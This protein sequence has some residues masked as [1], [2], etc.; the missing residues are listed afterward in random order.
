MRSISCVRL[1]I[2]GT[3]LCAGV[4]C[5]PLEPLSS[6]VDVHEWGTFTSMADWQGNALEGLHHTEEPLPKFVYRRG[7]SPYVTKG[8]ESMPTG[9][10]QKLETPVIYF[11]SA[12]P[13]LMHA[14]VQ[15][16]HGVVSEWFP[17]AH[18]FTPSIGQLA[19]PMT[20][21][22]ME[23]D[24][25]VIPRLNAFP[26]VASDD[27]WASSRK[28]A[29]TPLR[30]GKDEEQFIFYRGLGSFETALRV[31]YDAGTNQVTVANNSEESIEHIF[32]LNVGENARASITPLQALG[33]HASESST[34]VE[35][36][37]STVAYLNE[38]KDTVAAALTETG[39]FQD[40][41]RAMVDTWSH[42]YFQSSGVRILYT[43]P[44]KWTD[45]ILPLHLSPIPDKLVRTLVGRVEFVTASELDRI[46]TIL[47]PLDQMDSPAELLNQ[48]GRFAEPKLRLFEQLRP[49]RFN[50]D[51]MHYLI[52]AS[53]W[54]S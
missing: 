44:R 2:M 28:V 51:K 40:E 6:G 14:A 53:S 16:P 5:T 26:D 43:V 45:D 42:S 10:T 1:T 54:R 7:K 38:A 31:S 49:G 47:L 15:F 27:V 35:P 41:A 22:T 23:W 12:N 36:T 3:T 19:F 25:E 33:P 21:G 29:S 4:G 46:E 9:V 24:V 20:Q 50:T 11:Y 18:G 52:A 30:V 32:L 37:K 8:T 17:D 39:L 48:L 13:V 34:I